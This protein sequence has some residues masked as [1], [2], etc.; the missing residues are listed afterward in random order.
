MNNV[1]RSKR[2]V[3]AWLAVLPAVRWLA[4]CAP[5][6]DATAA[7][8]IPVVG[9][10]QL[11][12]LAKRRIYF[13]HQ[14]V[15]FNVMEGVEELAARHV[16]SGLK[17]VALKGGDITAGA[18][19][20]HAANG[21]NE[22]PLTK[23]DGFARTLADPRQGAVDIAFYKFCYVDIRADTDVDALFGRYKIAA[24]QLQ[25][26]YPHTTFVHLT[27]PLTVIQSGPKATLKKLL[28][29]PDRW[30]LDNVQRERFNDM[31]RREYANDHL[32][33]L[34]RLESTWEDGRRNGFDSAGRQVGA[35]VDDYSI[36]GKHLNER[37]RRWVAAHLVDYLARLPQS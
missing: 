23:I 12:T 10:E 1:I 4:A 35:L 13:G 16:G 33:D 20:M 3:L 27:A 8:P 28:G 17:V 29:R 9:D 34:A 11:S 22:Q 18:A 26:Q 24:G 25:Q 36:D 37:G 14:S 31:M 7:A 19:F 15:G 21:T 2:R 32:F 5:S 6:G 30:A